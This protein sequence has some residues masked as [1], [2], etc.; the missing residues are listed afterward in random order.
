MK[1]NAMEC[2]QQLDRCCFQMS[3]DFYK[4]TFIQCQYRNFSE[5]LYLDKD[6]NV[7]CQKL[8]DNNE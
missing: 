1:R 3:T 8:E 4:K 6:G 2:L 5:K 7:D